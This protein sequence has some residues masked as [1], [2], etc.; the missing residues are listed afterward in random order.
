MVLF[1]SEEAHLLVCE[2]NDEVYLGAGNTLQVLGSA[3][4]MD[5]LR[6]QLTNMADLCERLGSKITT[7]EVQVLA[8]LKMEEVAAKM[9]GGG[10]PNVMGAPVMDKR[11]YTIREGMLTL[12][13]FIGSYKRPF[14]R[15]IHPMVNANR[16]LTVI[17]SNRN[18]IEVCQ[19]LLAK[20]GSQICPEQGDVYR[21]L[22][23]GKAS[24]HS[25]Q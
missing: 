2:E 4:S 22:L 7:C 19:I 21:I 17:L 5:L 3:I 23:D 1:N 9:R 15:G 25:K 10:K 12:P 24:K 20:E 16:H 14:V 18:F 13:N 11:Y 6:K 8:L